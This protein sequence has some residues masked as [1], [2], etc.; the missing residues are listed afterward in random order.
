MQHQQQT[1]NPTPY[2][3]PPPP[4]QGMPSI[5]EPPGSAVTP[6][7]TEEKPTSK[8]QPAPEVDH[9]KD[10]GKG[11]GKHASAASA[12]IKTAKKTQKPA[13]KRRKHR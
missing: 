10:T 9:D 2:P 7:P 1:Q 8:R 13:L 5:N 6:E 12:R 3:A 4:D 11:K